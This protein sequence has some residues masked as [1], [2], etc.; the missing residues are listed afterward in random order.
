MQATA[1]AD[2]LD[3]RFRLT[4]Y[5]DGRIADCSDGLHVLA[6]PSVG[7]RLVLF[8][9]SS[10]RIVTSPVLRMYQQP[11]VYGTYFETRNSVYLLQCE[12]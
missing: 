11:G 1:S 9:P 2:P 10:R 4:T 6:S 12:A 8:T 3:R 7:S 5:R